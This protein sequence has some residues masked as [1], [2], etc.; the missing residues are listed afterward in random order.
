[1]VTSVVVKQ[2]RDGDYI[3]TREVV[4]RE[5]GHDVLEYARYCPEVDYGEAVR[6][7]GG[8]GDD[9]NGQDQRVA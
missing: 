4:Y 6:E 2:E 5:G 7:K 8:K 1:M 3:W 9:E